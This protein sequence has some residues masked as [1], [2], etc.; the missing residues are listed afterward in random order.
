MGGAEHVHYWEPYGQHDGA[1]QYQSYIC[2]ESSGGHP[3]QLRAIW[4]EQQQCGSEPWNSDYGQRQRELCSI[5][6]DRRLDWLLHAAGSCLL[7]GDGSEYFE[8]KFFVDRWTAIDARYRRDV[9]A[10]LNFSQFL[11][12]LYNGKWTIQR[13]AVFHLDGYSCLYSDD[14]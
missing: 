11:C 14:K 3:G 4:S 7:Q 6:L 9:E 13:F 8:R 1:V 12:H 5:H 10:E 2:A